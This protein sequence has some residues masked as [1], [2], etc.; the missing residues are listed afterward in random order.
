MSAAEVL[1][2]LKTKIHT[3]S[4]FVMD[5]HNPEET[6]VEAGGTY[7]G[8]TSDPDVMDVEITL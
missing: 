2:P 1:T 8:H 7:Q 4:L 5:N 3:I 6:D